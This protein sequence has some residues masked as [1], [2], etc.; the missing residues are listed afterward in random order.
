[1]DTKPLRDLIIAYVNDTTSVVIY[2]RNENGA[3]PYRVYGDNFI[4]VAVIKEGDEVK[5]VWITGNSEH[6][7]PI[8][9]DAMYDRMA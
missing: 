9:Y 2:D 6:K 3:E 7:H 5:E 1:M 8:N 4:K